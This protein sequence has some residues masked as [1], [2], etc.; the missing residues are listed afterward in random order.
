MFATISFSRKKAQKAQKDSGI[1]APFCGCFFLRSL[2]HFGCGHGSRCELFGLS[3]R[4]RELSS[5]HSR[6]V[7]R[8]FVKP[9]LPE[10]MPVAA[11]TAQKAD[12]VLRDVVR[13]FTQAQRVM[14]SCCSEATSKECEALMLI[15]RQ[16]GLTVQAFAGHMGLEKTW[17]SRLLVRME[18]DGLIKRAPNPSDSR[19]LLIEVTAKGKA[20]HRKLAGSLN[21]HAVNLLGCVPVAE[22]ANVERALVH[23]RDA[24]S[25]CLV[26]C[27]PKR[28]KC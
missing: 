25:E 11:S 23:L 21:E 26:K 12:T 1:F 13:L 28:G 10:S 15:A 5:V 27:G 18:K 24:L 16:R 14:T 9:P 8:V 2:C 19:S 20:E 7:I 22:R 17:A 3:S 6:L 4:S